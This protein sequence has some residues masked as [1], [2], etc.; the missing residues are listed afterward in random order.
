M[1]S[2]GEYIDLTIQIVLHMNVLVQI[3]NLLIVVF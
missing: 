2:G 1:S 3:V